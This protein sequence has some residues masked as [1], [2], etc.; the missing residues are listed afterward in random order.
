MV[1]I[2]AMKGFL[3]SKKSTNLLNLSTMTRIIEN[4]LQQGKPS[5]KFKEIF[6]HICGKIERGC[7]KSTGGSVSYLCYLHM[8]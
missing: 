4:P 6:P 8:E 2:L 7:N 1:I 5:I 3:K